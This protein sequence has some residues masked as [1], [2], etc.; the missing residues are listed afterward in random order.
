M[1][2]ITVQ[3]GARTQTI[4]LEGKVVGP[5]VEELNHTWHSLA[6]SVGSKKLQLDLSA[7]AFIDSRGRQLLREIYQKTNASF[8]TDSP[9]TRY[10]AEDAMHQSEK[11]GEKGV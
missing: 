5:W 7:V 4:K 9:L 6:S 1:L 11:D 10:F 2:R 3:E 8:L